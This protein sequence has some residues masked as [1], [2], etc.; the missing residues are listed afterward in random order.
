MYSLSSANCILAVIKNDHTCIKD[1]TC[2]PWKDLN[3]HGCVWG[4]DKCNLAIRHWFVMQ[5][6]QFQFVMHELL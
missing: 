2:I 3:I 5:D 6:T 1:K 4:I